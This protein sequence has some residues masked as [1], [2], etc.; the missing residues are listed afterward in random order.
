M[1]IFSPYIW[2]VHQRY[3]DIINLG[4]SSLPITCVRYTSVLGVLDPRAL[5]ALVKERLKVQER[6]VAVTDMPAPPLQHRPQDQ[7]R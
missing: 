4:E 1:I 3:P 6:S 2:L 7:L 5:S